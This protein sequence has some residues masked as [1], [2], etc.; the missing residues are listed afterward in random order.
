MCSGV[1]PQQPPTMFT[2]P[3]VANSPT[4][5]PVVSGEVLEPAAVLLAE[6]VRLD[7]LDAFL[8]DPELRRLGLSVQ[9]PH[10]SYGSVDQIGGLWQLGELS[11][12]LDRAAP[13]LGEHTRDVLS[14]LGFARAE[15]EEL[16]ESGAAA[17]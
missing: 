15:I 16:I 4:S 11:L 2:R 1:V 6:P 3:L 13:A 5:A 12:Q 10:A 17:G 9:Y 14:E 8:D 7:Q